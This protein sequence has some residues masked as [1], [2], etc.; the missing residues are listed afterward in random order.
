MTERIFNA[1]DIVWSPQ[2]GWGVLERRVSLVKVYNLTLTETHYTSDGKYFERDKHP[3]LFTPSQA[4]AL[5]Y[6]VPEEFKHFFKFNDNGLLTKLR[7]EATTNK[8]RTVTMYQALFKN[9]DHY[10]NM[11][12]LLFASEDEAKAWPTGRQF[13]KLLT[14]RPIEIEV[15]E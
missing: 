7:D 8:K 1:G 11:T 13:I 2:A 5:G 9:D 10:Y 15:E 14:D 4:I 12:D 3:S 6:E